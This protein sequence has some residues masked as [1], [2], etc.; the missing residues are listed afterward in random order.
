MAYAA[1]PAIADSKCFDDLKLDDRHFPPQPIHRIFF[2]FL[3]NVIFRS[4]SYALLQRLAGAA[5][6][7]SKVT[8]SLLCCF[9][10]AHVYCL[11]PLLHPL[12]HKARTS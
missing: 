12:S 11:Q 3:P 9:R 6:P 10:P 2:P 7:Q 1:P 5:P 4:G 8:N